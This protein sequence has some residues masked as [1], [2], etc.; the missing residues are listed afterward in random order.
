MDLTHPY[1]TLVAGRSAGAKPRPK[2]MARRSAGRPIW[3]AGRFECLSSKELAWK[4]WGP[5]TQILGNKTQSI[6]Y[7]TSSKV[8]RRE[9]QC[10]HCSKGAPQCPEKRSLTSEIARVML[11]NQD[12]RSRERAFKSLLESNTIDVESKFLLRYRITDS[13]KCT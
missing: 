10:T 5:T 9:S 7:Q 8:R 6:L 1:S 11:R 4:A 3:R 2:I 13:R 12:S